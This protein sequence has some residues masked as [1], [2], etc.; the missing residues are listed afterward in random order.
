MYT[1]FNSNTDYWTAI[2]WNTY[3]RILRTVKIVRQESCSLFNEKKFTRNLNIVLR[4]F[5]C[6]CFCFYFFAWLNLHPCQN[7]H[8]RRGSD[9][10][11]D[12]GYCNSHDK[13]ILLVLLVSFITVADPET[14]RGERNMKSDSAAAINCNLLFDLFYK[15][16][17][18]IL[19]L[20]RDATALLWQHFT[21]TRSI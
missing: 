16:G 14:G 3:R 15:T 19:P 18:A 4:S 21:P 7:T 8:P 1:I 12:L 17:G 9:S 11:G 13:Y 6:F 5:F 10:C 2:S 20:L